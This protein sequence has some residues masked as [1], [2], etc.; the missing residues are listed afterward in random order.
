MATCLNMGKKSTKSLNHALHNDKTL[1]YL[2]KS[3]D[4]LD[5]VITVAFYSSLYFVRYKLFPMKITKENGD[6]HVHE[7]FDNYC[8]YN[9]TS[10]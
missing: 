10:N 9:D 4:H 5:W 8:S 1:K 7:D 2:D 3:P 6:T